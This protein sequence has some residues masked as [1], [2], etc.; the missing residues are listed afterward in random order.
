MKRLNNIFE[1][2]IDI[3]NLKNA[4]KNARKDKSHYKEV[5]MVDNDLDKYMIEIQQML[6]DK[7]YIIDKYDVSIIHDKGK[8]RILHKLAY[9]PHRIIQWAVMLQ[10]ENAFRK[11]LCYHSCASIPGR[12]I[13]RAF[14]LCKKYV[15]KY[16]YNT[17]YCLKIDVKKFYPSI[18]K[19]ILK[20]KLRRLF[21]DKDLLWLLDLI[22]DSFPEEKGV[23]IGSYC[24]QYFANFY[25]SEFDHWLK[26]IKKEKYV[27]R[28]MDD[29]IIL[30]NDKTHL[31]NLC[32]E[33]KE[34]WKNNLK[35]EMKK[36]YQVFPTNK[37]G[38]DF[39]GYRVFE[40][41]VLLRK[42]SV[43]RLKTKTRRIYRK[44]KNNKKLKYRD[45]CSFNS[46]VGFSKYYDHYRLFSKYIEPLG[47]SIIDYYKNEVLS[48]KL[49]DKQKEK[50]VEKYSRKLLSKKYKK[51]YTSKTCAENLMWKDLAGQ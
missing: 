8:D 47:N 40:D 3:D 30:G 32:K 5:I 46:H 16:K 26:E 34:Y 10:I 14:K 28:Y 31:H 7:T 24:S 44:I 43:K 39:V 37:R 33:I 29:I 25:L 51:F 22:V 45:F 49:T 9:Y 18:D 35:L 19:N 12:G 13:E 27:I 4:H 1:K 21:K 11:Y 6:I 42:S 48:N 50:K 20:Q 36:N 38:V 23:P 17:K 15:Q 2:I 41:Y